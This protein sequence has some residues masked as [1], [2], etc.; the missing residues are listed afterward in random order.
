M[1]DLRL[2]IS[3]EELEHLRRRAADRGFSDVRA[4][5]L[6][7]LLDA[8]PSE[9]APDYDA[10]A[11]VKAGTRAELE[12]RLLEGLN[13]GPATELTAADWERIRAEALRRAAEQ[14]ARTKAS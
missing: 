4:F 10:P 7:L 3:E 6:A 9:T 14:R 1:T 11:H 13:S 8:L 5:A 12:A 2:P